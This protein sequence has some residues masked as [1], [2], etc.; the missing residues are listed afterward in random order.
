MNRTAPVAPVLSEHGEKVRS[1]LSTFAGRELSAA[2]VLALHDRRLPEKTL[3]PVVTPLKNTQPRR[4][5]VDTQD[6]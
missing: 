1:I 6:R 3:Y 4:R 2:E 5:A